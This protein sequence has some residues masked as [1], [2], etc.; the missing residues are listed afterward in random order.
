MDRVT[1]TVVPLPEI[2]SLYH[3][4]PRQPGPQDCY[5]EIRLQ[6]GQVSC[7]YNPEPG[8][9]LPRPVWSGRRRRIPIPC[10]TGPAANA[11]MRQVLPLVQRVLD[12]AS[13]EWMV[14]VLDA[15]A[16]AA[17]NELA[18]R[19]DPSQEWPEGDLITEYDADDWY[20]H[21]GE[22]PREIRTRLGITAD[23]TDEQLRVLAQREAAEAVKTA[24]NWTESHLILVGV[25]PYLAGLRDELV[26]HV[27]RLAD[28]NVLDMRQLDD[29]NDGELAS[30]GYERAT[31]ERKFAVEDRGEWIAW[32][33]TLDEAAELISQQCGGITVTLRYAEP[34]YVPVPNLV[35]NI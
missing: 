25:H 24:R 22:T 16:K 12:G 34:R 17:L 29:Y 8:N 23:T 5:L 33:D 7:G 1:A 11:L 20:S 30:V 14:G 35:P 3:R 28:F 6:D 18:D 2:D 9:A 26:G 4:Y 15:D 21:A 13:I 27:K 32:A 19:C 31:C 10:L